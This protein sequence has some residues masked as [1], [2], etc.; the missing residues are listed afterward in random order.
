MPYKIYRIFEGNLEEAK[1][2]KL[3]EDA[4][5][6]II[7]TSNVKPRIWVW[8]GKNASNKDKYFAGVSATKIKSKE[9]LYGAP[10]DHVEQGD[11]PN[12]FPMELL[13]EGRQVEI[14]AS[15][16][17]PG[18]NTESEMPESFGMESNDPQKLENISMASSSKP[19][20]TN[21]EKETKKEE[22]ED[23]EIPPH[24]MKTATV[25]NTSANIRKHLATQSEATLL[26]KDL[27]NL[28]TQTKEK[29][30][31]FLKDLSY[32]LENIRKKI[33]QLLMDL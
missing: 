26:E 30:K 10:I 4:I 24:Q 20:S 6:L 8:V 18:P 13:P 22:E 33:D 31:L 3:S 1:V 17:S 7:D 23:W 16:A 19:S 14:E 21:I 9:R 29:L 15:S 12:E 2:S 25:N 27:K 11:E 5:Y 32:D 28:P